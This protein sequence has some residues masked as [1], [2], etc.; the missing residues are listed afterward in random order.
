MASNI[1]TAAEAN[2]ITTSDMVK[3]REVDLVQQFTH[4]N[5]AGFVKALGTTRSI[6]MPA[7]TTLYVYQTTGTLQSGTVAEGDVIPLSK[8][9][10]TKSLA[11]EITLKKW[12]KAV[13]AEAIQK[14]GRQEA[15]NETDK[16]LISDIQKGIRTDF[17]T[18]LATYG[19]AGTAVAGNGLQE[20]LALAW[21][22][23]QVLF[24]DDTAQAVYF[25]NPED[26]SAYLG[27]AN[28]TT[29][30]A[31]GMNYIEDFLGLGTVI[32]SS[33]VTKGT[34]YATA[35]DNIIKYYIDMNGGDLPTEFNLTSDNLGL[36][37]V[38]S[39]Q[40]NERAQSEIMAMSGVK[41][42]VE[43]ADGVVIGTVDDSFLTDLTV[44]ADSPAQTFPWTDKTPA[45]FQEDVTVNGGEVAGTLT[46]I[47]GGLSP[48]GPLSGDGYFLAL[49]FSNFASGL[50]YSDVQVG[51]MPTEGTGMVTLDSDCDVVFKITDKNK[52]KVKVVQSKNGHTNVQYFGLKNLVLESTGV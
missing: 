11:G 8:Y 10:R 44:A 22:K 16:K 27:K 26:I 30:N 43:Y 6:A 5:L 42:L 20:T 49:K 52:Q 12:R 37:G 17:F 28:I 40:N 39:F 29:Q 18:D 46:F 4:T 1:T 34:I 35:K 51:L 36:V 33:Q 14:S 48:S 41:F 38:T 47:E 24:E 3:A 13:T 15:I 9:A 2:V 19:A 23:L 25:V 7:G 32:I 50:T 31:F 21:G 45:D